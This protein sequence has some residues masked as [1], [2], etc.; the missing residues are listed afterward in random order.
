MINEAEGD[1][2]RLDTL[3]RHVLSRRPDSQERELLAG[4]LS[5]RRL[6]Y[7]AAP[8]SARDL[9]AVG[10]SPLDGHLDQVELAAWTATARAVLNLHESI[11]RY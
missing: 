5:R 7:A 6:E 10:I 9:L 2:A 4:L 8:D 3:W 11:A 1:A